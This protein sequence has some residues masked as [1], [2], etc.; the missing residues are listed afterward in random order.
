MAMNG[1]ITHQRPERCC[2]QSGVNLAVAPCTA[3]DGLPKRSS[4]ARRAFDI[5]IRDERCCMSRARQNSDVWWFAHP[6]RRPNPL[7]PFTASPVKRHLLPPNFQLIINA[8]ADSAKQT[9]D[10]TKNPFSEKDRT[11][12]LS[13]GYPRTTPRARKDF[14]RKLYTYSQ[15]Q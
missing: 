3:H 5:L 1:P 11:L 2:I 7:S 13:R 6:S 4:R 9:I 10:L 15:T 12:K 14:Y 8:S